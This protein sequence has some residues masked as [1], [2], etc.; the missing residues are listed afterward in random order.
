M[1]WLL[2]LIELPLYERV[3]SIHI[4]ILLISEML[5]LICD[6]VKLWV[7][8]CKLV[9]PC[10]LELCFHKKTGPGRLFS[11]NFK[12][13]V[14]Q[15]ASNF[16]NLN[17]WDHCSLCDSPLFF[18]LQ[19]H[20]LHY[21]QYVWNSDVNLSVFWGNSLNML[22]FMAGRMNLLILRITLSSVA[23]RNVWNH[24]M[25]MRWVPH[26]SCPQDKSV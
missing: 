25:T 5:D 13:V 20:Y 14:A 10:D 15:L 22:Y 7:C 21:S 4:A 2:Y 23:S 11:K 6:R 8:A 19:N 9:H 12:H 1:F 18:F 16:N 17:D 26:F 24:C 3:S